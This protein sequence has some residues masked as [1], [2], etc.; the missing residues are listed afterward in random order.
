MIIPSG[1]VAKRASPRMEGWAPASTRSRMS[2]RPKR[3]PGRINIAEVEVSILILILGSG[4][5]VRCFGSE[6]RVALL[7]WIQCLFRLAVRI[8]FVVSK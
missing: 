7:N 5:M 3:S 6:V 8:I 4:G 1:E 2:R